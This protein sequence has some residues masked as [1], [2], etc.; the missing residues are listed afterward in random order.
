MDS[1]IQHTPPPASG[2]AS[3]RPHLEV[4]EERLQRVEAI[5]SRLIDGSTTQDDIGRALRD[6]GLHRPDTILSVTQKSVAASP[7]L[8]AEEAAAKAESGRAA[9]PPEPAEDRAVDKLVERVGSHI[10]QTLGPMLQHID[11]RLDQLRLDERLSA[12]QADLTALVQ[13]RTIKDY[14]STEEVAKIVGRDAYTVREWCRLGR[15]RAEK[16]ECGRGKSAG[17]A[18]PHAE[19]VRYQNE[20]L[21]PQRSITR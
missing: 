12:I 3:R 19:L 15:I 10:E 7:Y 21:L 13:Q 8:N 18:V 5:L 16:R 11:H 1:A 6:R 17:W 20:G 9:R 2:H 14:Y 4:L